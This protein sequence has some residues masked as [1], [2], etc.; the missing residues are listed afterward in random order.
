MD[1]AATG[2]A[3]APDTV[4]VACGTYYEHDI[5]VQSDLVLRS[6]SGDPSCVTID[7][8]RLG[9][10]IMV[11]GADDVT[12][13]GLTIAQGLKLSFGGGIYVFESSAKITHCSFVENE[14]GPSGFGGGLAFVN[15]EINLPVQ[16]S[17][18]EVVAPYVGKDVTF[19]VRPEDIFPNETVPAGRNLAKI[20]A[21]V[22][23]VEPMGSEQYIYLTAEDTPFI[24]RIEAHVKMDVE[25]TYDLHVD[26]DQTHF[27]E[28]G[29]DGKALT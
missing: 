10:A 16:K 15:G 13:E 20:R 14:V 18:E 6:D 4:E 8:G 7:A 2:S 3:G 1:S 25:E 21:K 24:A 17:Q 26:M 23:V 12:I 19:G 5:L 22:E 29:E 27:F 9:R 11:D 28:G